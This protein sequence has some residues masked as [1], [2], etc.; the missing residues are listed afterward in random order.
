MYDP[1]IAANISTKMKFKLRSEPRRRAF[2]E[3]LN[4]DNRDFTC[5]QCGRPVSA[6]RIVAGVGN[7]NHCPHCLASRHLDL[8]RAGDRL[9]ACKGS[10]QAAGLTLKR[11][12]KKYQDE[13]EL[14]IVHLCIECGKVSANRLAADDDPDSIMDLFNES[15]LMD[16]NLSRIFEAANI[17][18][19]KEA[20]L[21]LVQKQLYGLCFQKT[22][23]CF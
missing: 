18:L 20:D 16:A 19:L 21:L 1:N 10:M 8:E 14:M 9:S 6:G 11:S 23:G 3:G 7:R 4:P 15:L 2:L 5:K 17:D 12:K 22:G 13:G